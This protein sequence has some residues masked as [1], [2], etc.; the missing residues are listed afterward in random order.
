MPQRQ[1]NPQVKGK[2]E[3]EEILNTKEQKAK[4]P[5]KPLIN[6]NQQR[7][8]KVPLTKAHEAF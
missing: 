6:P 5:S 2:G 3:I 8:A 4:F 7:A 1:E